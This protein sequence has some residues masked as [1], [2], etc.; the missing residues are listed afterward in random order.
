MVLGHVKLPNKTIAN[1]M[2]IYNKLYV[3]KSA[4]I[5]RFLKYF[6]YLAY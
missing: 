3:D 1:V 5:L 6:K 2:L 4:I